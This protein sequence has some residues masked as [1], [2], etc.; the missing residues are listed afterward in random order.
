MFTATGHVL[1]K[2]TEL[3]DKLIIISHKYS[4]NA[5]PVLLRFRIYK[6]RA[7]SLSWTVLNLQDI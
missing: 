6:N 7:S 1:C 3:T 4:K 5:E 2:T